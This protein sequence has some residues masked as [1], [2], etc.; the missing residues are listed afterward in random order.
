MKIKHKLSALL[1]L[2]LLVSTTAVIVL[3][4]S[5]AS[6]N[7]K[8]NALNDIRSALELSS[9]QL[10]SELSVVNQSLDIYIHSRE[11]QSGDPSIFLP[12]LQGEIKRQQPHFEKF[13][14]GLPNGT[15]YNTA[16]GNPHLGM[17]R[18]FDDDNAKAP[19]YNIA[20]RDYWQATI[21]QNSAALPVTFV[22]QPMISYTTGKRQVVVASAIVAEGSVI[23]LLGVSLYWR[24]IEASLERL[25]ANY[26]S[27]FDWP[28]RL[29]L[30]DREG[31]YWYH[32]NPEKVVQKLADENGQSVLDNS[33]QPMS[34]IS[35]IKDE[36]I[37][38]LTEVYSGNLKSGVNVVRFRTQQ[39]KP[40]LYFIYEI[41]PHSDYV[42][43]LIVSRDELLGPLTQLQ[44]KYAWLLG[45]IVI[46]AW[47]AAIFIA[48]LIS[49]PLERLTHAVN[50]LSK[51]KMLP[52]ASNHHLDEIRLLSQAFENIRHKFIERESDLATSE[53]RFEYAMQGANDGLWDWNLAN[54][55]VFY[56]PRW[57]TMLG[58]EPEGFGTSTSKFFQVIH[59]DDKKKVIHKA[60]A[61][62]SGK[63]DKFRM[64]LRLKT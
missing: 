59:R 47:V 12:Y 14:Y 11:V 19:P 30:T 15:F 31:N 39:D 61:Y 38:E 51:G 37:S 57:I 4:L 13:I 22:S 24:D 44:Q 27:R 35:N 40:G 9:Q 6:E 36:H 21:A 46:C 48:H 2:L 29:M 52:I 32:W 58:Y 63:I 33:G 54:D 3:A 56:S 49:A 64:T 1:S 28:A 53:S 23:G 34:L 25:K 8:Q 17:L 26:F 7:F 55:E 10:K 50:A 45:I 43:G 41:I 16:G 42:L 18:S 62:L 20:Q 60:D 5:W